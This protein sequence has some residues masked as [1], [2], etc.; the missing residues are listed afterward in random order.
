[1]ATNLPKNVADIAMLAQ[2]LELHKRVVPA[3]RTTCD[4]KTE[5]PASDA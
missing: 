1:M 5:S 4:A 2:L 3:P